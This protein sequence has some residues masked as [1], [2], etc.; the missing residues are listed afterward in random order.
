VKLVHQFTSGIAGWLTFE[1]MRRGTDNLSESTLYKPL[2]EIASGRHFEVKQQFA[3]PK[4]SPGRGAEKTIDFV[5]VDR[6]NT[7]ILALEVKYKR[8]GRRMA[9]SLSK[10][11]VKLRD[12][13]LT[14][15][16]Q[17]I[18]AGKAGNIK[19]SV[20]GFSLT[21]AVLFVWRKDD[22]VRHILDREEKPI[23]SQLAKLVR[24]MIPDGVEFN[25]R[26]LAE[27][28]LAGKAAKPVGNNYGSLRSGS[29]VTNQRF[30]VATFLECDLWN[31]L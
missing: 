6:A 29:T 25:A 30:W 5:V 28:F 7:A 31:S 9:G 23:K 14:D 19:S 17:T 1:Q 22:G 20:L 3:I 18:A 15:V 10:D 13:T 21:K 11:A 2:E 16:E 26:N 12:F 27:C 4:K 8:T 24:K